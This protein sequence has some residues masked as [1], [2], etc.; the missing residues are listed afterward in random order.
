MI[1]IVIEMGEGM[2]VRV[3]RLP[4]PWLVEDEVR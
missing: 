2:E 1:E 3:H 4:Q